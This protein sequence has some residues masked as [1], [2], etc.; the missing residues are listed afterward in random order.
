MR[1][2]YTTARRSAVLLAIIGLT[3]CDAHRSLAPDAGRAA[4]IGAGLVGAVSVSLSNPSFE[5]EDTSWNSPFSLPVGNLWQASDGVSSVDLNGVYPYQNVRQSFATNPYM[6]YTVQFDL[7]GN[8]GAPQGL[9]SIE[10]QVDQGG[11]QVFMPF[12]EQVDLR[13]TSVRRARYDFNTTG[14]STSNMGWQTM[15]FTFMALG[16]YTTLSFYGTDRAQAHGPALDN[17]R[18]TYI[19]ELVTRRTMPTP[20]VSFGPGPFVYT[21]TAF[22]VSDIV[23]PFQMGS[24]TITYTGNCTDVGNQC[25]A[26]AFMLGTSSTEATYI[27]I[28][29][30]PTTTTVSCPASVSYTGSARTPCTATVTGPGLSTSTPVS[31]ADNVSAGTATATAGFAG[32][33]NL[34]ASSASKTFTIGAAT[35]TAVTFGPGPFVY[36][37]AA[38]TATASVSPAA[39]G[40][41]NI[42]YSGDCTGAGST[43]TATATFAGGS[44]YTGSTAT[45][46]ITIAKAATTTAVSCP[47]SVTYTTGAQTP[48]TAGVTG[49]GLSIAPAPTY[50]DNVNA[51]TATAAYTFAGTANLLASSGSKTFQITRAAS[52]TTVSCPASVT[53]TGAALVPCSA[54]ATGPGLGSMALPVVYA[55]NTAAGTAS[56]SASFVGTANLT[57]SSDAR[58]FTIEGF[59]HDDG[60]V[61]GGA[62]LPHREPLHRDRHGQPRR[63][64]R[65]DNRLHRRLHQRR[66]QLHGDG[67]VCRQWQ[68]P[69]ERRERAHHH[70]AA[71]GVVRRAVQER[72]LG[73]PD[74]RPGH[75]VQEPGRL[76]ELRRH[77]GEEQGGWRLSHSQRVF[78][79]RILHGLGSART[80]PRRSIATHAS[81]RSRHVNSP[82]RSRTSGAP[83]SALGGR[84]PRRFRKPGLRSGNPACRTPRGQGDAWSRHDR[85]CRSAR[86]ASRDPRTARCCFGTKAPWK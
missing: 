86:R 66:K 18:V 80:Q 4:V 38:F 44:L 32:T 52:S 53:Y 41:A 39:A 9:K 73:V 12:D 35:T 13:A 5:I 47:A 77:E 79:E 23:V 64:G 33:A 58:S 50:T 1:F 55:N 22:T 54:T 84:A 78:D 67:D 11:G 70:Q 10:V 6:M 68:L 19:P 62:V 20:A 37:G 63:G 48:C 65:G 2:A 85:A 61:R 28:T 46:S 15:T 3:S 56:A 51:G 21:G 40:S 36:S 57:G 60:D 31:Y 42:V 75:P 45:T 34:L 71:G 74:R 83:G 59:N 27:T 72:R 8:P 14:K 7:A 29:A 26:Q 82:P 69:G 81:G 43:C 17:V 25:Y 16:D 30:A 24:T 49:L 76:R